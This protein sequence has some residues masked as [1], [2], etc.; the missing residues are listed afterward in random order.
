MG[1]SKVGQK[2][3]AGY[4]G[5]AGPPGNATS[6]PVDSLPITII[7]PPGP[8]GFKGIKVSLVFEFLQI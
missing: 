5:P 4:P 7:G 1:V 2:G 8:Q 6:L 3:E